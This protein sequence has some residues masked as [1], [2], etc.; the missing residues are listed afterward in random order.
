MSA[1]DTD[2]VPRIIIHQELMAL[3]A[4]IIQNH[5]AAGQVASGRT[6]KSL[7][8]E[9]DENSGRLFGRSFFGVLETGRRAG[10]VPRR[11]YL[12][13]LQWMKD[14]GIQAPPMPYKTNRPHKY[15]PA[16]RGAR[17]MAAAIAQTIHKKGTS[18]HRKGGRN[19]IYTNQIAITKKNLEE[20]LSRFIIQKVQHIK[21][22]II[23]REEE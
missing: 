17:S 22:T 10:R 20:R 16:E 14:K 3:K 12:I 18:L 8:V 2:T 21:P 19:D 23:R 6:M 13:I 9:V 15:T 7:R 5:M 11:F 1:M 4:E